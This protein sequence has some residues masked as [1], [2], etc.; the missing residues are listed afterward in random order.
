MLITEVS[1]SAQLQM[2]IIP[3]MVDSQFSQTVITDDS[4]QI[5]DY[6]WPRNF[7]KEFKIY[8]EIFKYLSTNTISKLNL[9]TAFCLTELEINLLKNIAIVDIYLLAD[10]KF[11][12]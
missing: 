4:L 1:L 5:H 10:F 9:F 2:L 8:I 6:R 12:R 7:I 3:S 11:R